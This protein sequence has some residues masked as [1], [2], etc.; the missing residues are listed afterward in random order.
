MRNDSA[1]PPRLECY[2]E[3][4]A[5]QPKFKQYIEKISLLTLFA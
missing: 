4:I 3:K 1:Y 5:Y 2:T